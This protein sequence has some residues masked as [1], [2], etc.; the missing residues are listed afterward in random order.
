M[1]NL[2]VAIF[3]GAVSLAFSFAARAADTEF[4]IFKAA[5]SLPVL[6][7]EEGMAVDKQL[8]KVLAAKDIIN[9]SLGRGLDFKVD[10]K[11]EMLALAVAY[12]DDGQMDYAPQVVIAVPKTRLI[13]WNPLAAVPANR[14]VKTVGTLTKLEYDRLY[15]SSGQ[16]GQG[17]ATAV[18]PEGAVA[19]NKFFA[20][21]L[22]GTGKLTQKD[23]LGFLVGEAF[24]L[25]GLGGRVKFNYTDKTHPAP[26]FLVNGVVVKGMLTTSGK[27]LEPAFFRDEGF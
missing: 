24:S 12:E 5:A 14:W 16:K 1:K 4:V 6:Y 17:F 26:G 19:E 20:V 18:I 9:L 8:T 27:P 21:T 3:A 15:T 23:N 11:T 2:L 25:T 10:T 13:I 22:S 7:V